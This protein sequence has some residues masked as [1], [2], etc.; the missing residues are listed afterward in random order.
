MPDGRNPLHVGA[1]LAV[2]RRDGTSRKH[3][4]ACVYVVSKT[5]HRVGG[6][7]PL[8]DSGDRSPRANERI[9]E[10]IRALPKVPS[11]RGQSRTCSCYAEREA[12]RRRQCSRGYLRVRPYKQWRSSRRVHSA[13]QH[14]SA[15]VR[16]VRLLSRRSRWS[17][18]RC[19]CR[20][21]CCR[22]RCPPRPRCRR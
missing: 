4:I 14:I 15:R 20:C 3:I 17:R 12:A 18:C 5:H 13:R 11:K 8:G 21:Q 19:R 9:A 22:C 7:R 16:R 6:H 10:F 1:T 2:A